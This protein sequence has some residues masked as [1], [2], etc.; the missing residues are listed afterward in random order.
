MEKGERILKKTGNEILKEK[1]STA[2]NKWR[3][4]IGDLIERIEIK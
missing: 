2:I 4:I 3:E 1:T